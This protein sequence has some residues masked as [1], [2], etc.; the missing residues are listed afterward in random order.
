[1]TRL[2]GTSEVGSGTFGRP[3]FIVNDPA[4]ERAGAVPPGSADR[5]TSASALPAPWPRPS[6][7]GMIRPMEPTSYDLI[8]IG[9]GPAGESASGGGGRLRQAGG[10]HRAQPDGRRRLDQYRH[11]AQQ[12]PARDGAGHLG[13]QGARPLRRGPLAP[14]RGHRRRV[15]VPR[16]PGHRQRA[17]A[18]RARVVAA[19]RRPVPRHRVVPRSPHGPRR[20]PGEPPRRRPRARRPA[21]SR[22]STRPPHP[23]DPPAGRDDPDR[24]RDA[25]PSVPRCS[26]SATPGCSTPTPSSSSS[27]CR[28]RWPSSARGSSAAEYA[29]TFAALGT[30]VWVVD[31]RDELLPFLDDEVSRALEDSMHGQLGIEFL[32]KNRVTKCEAH[33]YGDITLEFDTGGRLCVDAVLVAAGR[34][35]NTAELNLAAA[36][37]EPGARGLL[38]RG[39]PLPHRR[40]AHLR[41]RRRHRLP[42]PG[43]HQHGAGPRRHVPRLQQG[44]QDRPGPHP[45]H[46]DLH[47]PRGQ[48]GRRDRG[49]PQVQGG[50]L[51]RRPRVVCA[52]RPR[53]DHRRPGRVP[54]AALSAA[55]T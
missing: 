20:H 52:L 25:R 44:A 55:R 37:L 36:G 41:R 22:A 14:P 19:R 10:D 38:D 2:I 45:A 46:R 48:H 9:S 24:H 15:H 17:Q 11:P 34:A 32:W 21:P 54:Q 12:D 27:G 29:C 31:G 28:G 5:P 8:V 33:D 47:H 23:R 35:S 40:P 49:R 26:P 13:A 6:R 1:M 7:R 16:A 3:R 39:R 50:R 42:R 53:R 18:G 51:H 4:T 30:E 43:L